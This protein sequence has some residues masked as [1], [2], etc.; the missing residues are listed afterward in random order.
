M[1]VNITRRYVIL[2]YV[3]R[4]HIHIRV[5]GVSFVLDGCSSSNDMTADTVSCDS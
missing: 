3:I 4:R 5:A 2:R 1:Q